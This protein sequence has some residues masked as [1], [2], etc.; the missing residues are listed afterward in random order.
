MIITE[1]IVPSAVVTRPPL[2]T[3]ADE[4]RRLGID[5][6]GV[7]AELTIT[8]PTD[9]ATILAA[10]GILVRRLATNNLAQAKSWIGVPDEH[11]RAGIAVPTDRTQGRDDDLAALAEAYV[12]GDSRRYE[13]HRSRIEAALAPFEVLLCAVSRLRITAGGTLTVDGA[14]TILAVRELAIEEGGSIVVRMPT[15]LVADTV[16]TGAEAANAARASLTELRY[17]G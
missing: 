15:R 8:T 11:I 2:S 17:D 10:D 3:V 1:A 4:L 5:E 9:L 6:R 12:F 16:L 13:A 7:R 14:A